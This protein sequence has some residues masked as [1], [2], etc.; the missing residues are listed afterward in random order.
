VQTPELLLARVIEIRTDC[1]DSVMTLDVRRRDDRLVN[2]ER[3]TVQ[4][5][6]GFHFIDDVLSELLLARIID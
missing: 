1:D 5:T 2:V 3:F 6:G 4:L